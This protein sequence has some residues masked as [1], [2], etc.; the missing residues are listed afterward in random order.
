M[1]IGLN[2]STATEV[3]TR[4][5]SGIFYRGWPIADGDKT[6][7]GNPVE[8]TFHRINPSQIRNRK[9]PAAKQRKG[10]AGIANFLKRLSMN[11]LQIILHPWHELCVRDN[12]QPK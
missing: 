7:G 8:L 2:S 4:T 12:R 9:F 3:Q 11:D 5:D 10:G 6:A 1:M